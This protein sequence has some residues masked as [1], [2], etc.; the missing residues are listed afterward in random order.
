MKVGQNFVKYFIRFLGN[1][2][3]RKNAFEIYW[4]LDGAK[5][6][7]CYQRLAFL[8][9]F[10]PWQLIQNSAPSSI[11]WRQC[12]IR[13]SVN[14]VLKFQF[15]VDNSGSCTFPVIQIW[16]GEHN[17]IHYMLRISC[18]AGTYYIHVLYRI[19]C[20]PHRIWM[21]DDV[22]LTRLP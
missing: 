19:L 8:I 10:S 7:I 15:W 17:T 11:V 3:S 20:S 13:I 22:Q 12:D 4:P 2:V 21:S 1:G 5:F 9:S 18:K 6:W 14:N 16:R